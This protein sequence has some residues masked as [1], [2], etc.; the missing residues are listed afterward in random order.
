MNI[1]IIGAT[2]GIG[3][4]LLKEYATSENKVGIVGRRKD[5]LKEIEAD[6]PANIFPFAA[7]ITQ[8]D[9]TDRAITYFQS[10]LATIDLVF[11]C[12]GTGELNPLLDFKLE[13]PTLQTNVVGWTYLMDC[14]YNILRQQG[15]GHL[16]AITS[17]GGLRGEA[18]APAY[19]ASKAYQ[20]NYLEA[21]RKK[22]YKE[23]RAVNITDIRPG[24]VDTRM[25][26]GENLFWV[27]PVE[28][29][30]S[31]IADGIKQK[32]SKVYITKRWHILAIINKNLPYFL[33][34]K[35]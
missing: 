30:V 25:A 18:Q 33:Y 13:Y 22:A 24:L 29:V 27:M 23:C 5:I 3:N 34:K 1:I 7:D 12:S 9:Q 32:K 4:G 16:V 35:M 15:F 31:Q 10:K 21:M 17:I 28:K 2:S 14:F 20:I 6:Y 11:V 26:K 8:T 19:S